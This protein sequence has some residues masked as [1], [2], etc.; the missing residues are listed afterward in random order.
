MTVVAGK[1]ANFR[2]RAVEGSL[3]DNFPVEWNVVDDQMA[4]QSTRTVK[5]SSNMPAKLW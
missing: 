1:G 2:L 3:P 4:A 5:Q